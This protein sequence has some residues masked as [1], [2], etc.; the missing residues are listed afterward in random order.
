MTAEA[1]AR[2]LRN[3]IF[4]ENQNSNTR[5]SL[6]APKGVEGFI[7]FAI[8]DGVRI[9]MERC[10]GI[11]QNGENASISHVVAEIRVGQNPEAKCPKNTG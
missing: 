8:R 9:E 7:T 2:S 5:H 1:R 6:L 3:L 10:I 4:G 11:I